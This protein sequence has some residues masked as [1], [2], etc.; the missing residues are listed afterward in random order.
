MDNGNAD[1][2]F[3]LRPDL[4]PPLQQRCRVL[5]ARRER[6][7]AACGRPGPVWEEKQDGEALKRGGKRRFVSGEPG[8]RSLPPGCPRV[9]PWRDS[10]R[11]HGTRGDPGWWPGFLSRVPSRARH[12][13]AFLRALGCAASFGFKDGFKDGFFPL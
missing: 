10:V 11:L 3:S 12:L 9:T 5:G 13:P 2:A 6:G 1:T 4:P 7:D 8:L